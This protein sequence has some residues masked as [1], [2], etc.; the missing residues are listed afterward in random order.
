[1]PEDNRFCGVESNFLFIAVT[2]LDKSMCGADIPDQS[3]FVGP[4]NRPEKK[5][6]LNESSPIKDQCKDQTLIEI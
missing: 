4:L 2:A 1:M 3:S 5:A 6:K